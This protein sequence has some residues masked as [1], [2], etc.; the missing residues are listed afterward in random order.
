M[1]RNLLCVFVLGVLSLLPMMSSHAS[2]P[3]PRVLTGC[4]VEG[5]FFSVADDT[6]RRAYRIR[7]DL[8][9]G[10]FEGK[11]IRVSGSLLP[12]DRFHV[13]PGT[14]EVLGEC[15]QEWTPAIDRQRAWVYEAEARKAAQQGQ[16][17]EAHRYIDR[18]IGMDGSNCSFL[19][20]RARFWEQQ[21][22]ADLAL[23]DME[24]AVN[25][26]HDSCRRY[27]ELEFLADLL[28]G[29]GKLQ[30]GVK[31][32]ERAIKACDYQP[33][34]DRLRAKMK[35]LEETGKGNPSESHKQP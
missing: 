31:A 24:Q 22:K 3:V 26:G 18:A 19:V 17:D 1:K 29:S 27:P 21:G 8:D 4:V 5:I 28:A 15:N 25:T 10:T 14:V 23:K 20:T 12:G 32:Y 11:K 6:G 7:S 13:Y 2:K 34:R 16:W 33:D 9:L 35:R 30:E